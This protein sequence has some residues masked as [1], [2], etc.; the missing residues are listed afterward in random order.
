MIS[1]DFIFKAFVSSSLSA[2]IILV[3]ILLIRKQRWHRPSPKTMQL[4]WMLALVKLLIP[5]A[6]ESPISLF[7]LLPQPIA[8]WQLENQTSM[9]HLGSTSAFL[10]GT[11]QNTAEAQSANELQQYSPQ[12]AAAPSGAD[13]HIAAGSQTSSSYENSHKP[14]SWFKAAGWIWLCGIL[15]I[16][17]YYLVVHIRFRGR[18]LSSREL[19][20]AQTSSILEEVRKGLGITRAIPVYEAEDIRSPFLY[21]V[22]KSE[23]YIPKD[24]AAI[25]NARQ[26]RH[27]FAHELS[28]YKRKDLWHNLLWMLAAILHW[29]N[30][31]VWLVVKKASSDRETACDASTLEALGEREATPSR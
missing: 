10:A 31:L 26:L 22:W 12:I 6:P 8:E 27:I 25:A 15:I 21:G 14:F 29:Y 5:V 23:I 16:S 2:V 1:P 30:P 20:G 13:K 7:N 4:L 24:I 3:L 17:C 28:H 11:E 19:A 18:L 9:L